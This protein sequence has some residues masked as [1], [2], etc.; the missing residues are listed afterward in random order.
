MF[1]GLEITIAT[2]IDMGKISLSTELKVAVN[3]NLGPTRFQTGFIN[4][5]ALTA[6]NNS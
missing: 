4:P 5:N 2:Y 3:L 6:A 1:I